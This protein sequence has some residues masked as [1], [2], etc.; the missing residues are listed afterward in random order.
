MVWGMTLETFTLV[1]VVLS[2][3][4]IGAGFV[5]VAGLLG[6]NRQE[7]WTA[8]FLITTTATTIT[9]FVF[10]VDHLL[11]V[12][13]VGIVSVVVLAV[14]ILARYGLHL[15]GAWRWIYVITATIALYLNVL[16]G[17]TQA[18]M[19]ISVLRVMAPQL[20]EPPFVVTQLT[21]LVSFIM[22]GIVAVKR[23]RAR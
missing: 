15:A 21:V 5:V 20:T 16:V 9:G 2:L 10:P 3:V 14:A 8:L 11:P 4:G 7:G 17:V 1:H 22:L 18:F 12:H 23:F 19:K 13:V 6:G